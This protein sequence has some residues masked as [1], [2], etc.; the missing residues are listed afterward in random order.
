MYSISSQVPSFVI[1]NNFQLEALIEHGIYNKDWTTN[2]FMF[3][4]FNTK[5]KSFGKN[6]SFYVSLTNYELPWSLPLS[7]EWLIKKKYMHKDRLVCN[8]KLR[9]MMVNYM[10]TIGS[11]SH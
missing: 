10:V 1:P 9:Y 8:Y 5:A 3:N 4:F 2:S 11:H 7:L 6:L